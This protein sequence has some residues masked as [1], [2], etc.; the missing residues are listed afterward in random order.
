M[1]VE[2]IDLEQARRR[3]PTPRTTSREP[4]TTSS[5]R[6]LEREI[7]IAEAQIEAAARLIW[8]GR[9]A[10]RDPQPVISGQGISLLRET[11]G[12]CYLRRRR[13]HA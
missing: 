10:R 13:T 6:A 12:A 1:P 8:S 9:D 11:A 4:R 5:A 7:R 2:E 3:L